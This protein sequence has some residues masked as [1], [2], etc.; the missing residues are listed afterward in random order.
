MGY[1]RPNIGAA[2]RPPGSAWPGFECPHHGGALRDDGDALVCPE[3]HTFPIVGGIP[4]FVERDDYAAAF[5]SQWNRYPRTQLDSHTGTTISRD[6]AHR[7]IGDR[8]W[9]NVAGR[10][11]LECGCGA[12]RFTEVL[13]ERDAHVTSVDLSSAVE[14]N[15]RNFPGERHRVVQ[16]DLLQLPFSPRSYDLV[17]CLGVV[18]HTPD[19]EIAVAR[20]YDQVAPGG[21]LVFDHYAFSASWLSWYLSLRPLWRAWL[22]RLPAERGLEL[23]ER[24]V[25][26]FLPLHRHSGSARRLLVSRVSPVMAYYHLLP[27]LS[28]DLQREWAL[29]DTHDSL[30]DWFKRFRSARQLERTLSLLG[31]TDIECVRRGVVVEARCRRPAAS[32]V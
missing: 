17:F 3:G 11:V 29:L 20:L 13:L 32:R 9:N 10:D 19:T 14:A 2:V 23:T 5:G 24:L 18:Q 4:R 15:R 30:T 16:A 6:R 21:T 28:D 1:E 31:A 22:R 8:T 7:A 27:E 26:R 12:G 25:D